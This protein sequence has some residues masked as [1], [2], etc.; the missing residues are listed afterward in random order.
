M[1]EDM[2][3]RVAGLLG[4][5]SLILHAIPIIV[6]G[7]KEEERRMHNNLHQITYRLD[8][9]EEQDDTTNALEDKPKKLVLN[10]SRNKLK[11]SAP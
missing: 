11:R 9:Q 3:M 7:Y 5:G 10:A 6:S 2:I 4:V 1:N 8:P